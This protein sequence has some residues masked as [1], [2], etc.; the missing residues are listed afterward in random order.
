MLVDVGNSNGYSYEEISRLVSNE[1][2]RRL[3]G[4]MSYSPTVKLIK[5]NVEMWKGPAMDCLVKVQQLYMDAINES[6]TET[7]GEFPRLKNRVLSIL[8]SK[9]KDTEGDV[10]I[11]IGFLI[12]QEHYS[13]FTLNSAHFEEMTTKVFT[14]FEL[15]HPKRKH[16][17]C[18]HV[19]RN[20]ENIIQ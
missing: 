18:T 5:N 19:L 15:L 6:V 14:N 8:E 1:Q 16:K 7:L 11:Q 3:P 13:P 12:S 20:D 2:G 9:L 10:K 17:K 4:H